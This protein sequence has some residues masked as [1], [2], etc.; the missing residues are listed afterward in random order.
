[1]LPDFYLTASD[2]LQ[3]LVDAHQKIS[4][5]LKLPPTESS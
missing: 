1:V 3:S 5:A 4:Y 2:A